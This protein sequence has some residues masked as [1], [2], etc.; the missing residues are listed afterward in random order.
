MFFEI[1]R[2]ERVY[3]DLKEWHQNG[4]QMPAPPLV[5][6]EVLLRNV[7]NDSTIIETGTHTGDTSAILLKVANNVISIEADEELF[8]K[9]SKRFFG[10]Q[11]II[12]LKGDSKLVFPTLI[13]SLSGN[14]SF[15][16]DGHYSGEGT[17]LGEEKTPI[18][19][20]LQSIQANLINFQKICV[21]VDDI[22][23]FSPELSITEGYP[24]LNYLVEWAL[25]NNLS[26]KIEH[27]IFIAKNY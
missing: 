1:V 7:I 13:P 5:K 16:L 12:I 8:L 21:L 6:R 20:E 27:D 14:V 19:S 18:I 23:L 24:S 10:R 26:W 22:R 9:A 17:F 25:H 11:K 3:T 2:Y 15:W 4:Y